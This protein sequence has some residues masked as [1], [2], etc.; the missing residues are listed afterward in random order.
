MS[1]RKYTAVSVSA[2]PLSG[3][4]A[5]PGPPPPSSSSPPSAEQWDPPSRFESRTMGNTVPPMILDDDPLSS[6]SGPADRS[7][8]RA[9]CTGPPSL[10]G[11]SPNASNASGGRHPARRISRNA[12]GRTL[13]SFEGRGTRLSRLTMRPYVPPL[14]SSSSPSPSSSF[15][16]PGDEDEDGPMVPSRGRSGNS[17]VTTIAPVFRCLPVAR[18]NSSRRFRP[19]HDEKTNATSTSPRWTYG[20]EKDPHSK[21]TGARGRLASSPSIISPH[22]SSPRSSPVEGGGQRRA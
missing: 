10:T 19:M 7:I 11:R 4:G 22:S 12:R 21:F 3:S 2:A 6:S 16:S 9:T 14:S 20:S 18:D 17:V 8:C 1:P 15:S 5:P 13:P